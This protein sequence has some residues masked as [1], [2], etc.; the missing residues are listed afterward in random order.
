MSR[1]TPAA[2]ENRLLQ[3]PKKDIVATIHIICCNI[4]K[5]SLQQG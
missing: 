3:Q 4:E 5:E 2:S 1:T